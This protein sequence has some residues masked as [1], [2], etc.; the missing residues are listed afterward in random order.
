[1]ATKQKTLARRPV[2]VIE[3]NVRYIV[4]VEP[5]PTFFLKF[6]GEDKPRV[7]QV[8]SL[9]WHGSYAH[10]DEICTRLR[11]KGY[12]ATVS[13]IFGRI[14]NYRALE[15]EREIQRAKE[16]AFWGE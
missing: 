5:G 2:R 15:A 14:M 7:V 10:G 6:D 13:D 3:D 12:T 1:M 11:E 9:A 8:P 16:A 4:R